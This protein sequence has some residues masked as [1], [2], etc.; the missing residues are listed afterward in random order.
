MKNEI[1][2]TIGW[3]VAIQGVL[4]FVGRTWFD[5]DWGL[6][7]LWFTPPTALYIAMAVVGAALA[8][9]GETAKK[10]SKARTY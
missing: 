1:V 7:H 4:G 9:V 3:V 6:L 5:N 10:R 2:L 8:Y